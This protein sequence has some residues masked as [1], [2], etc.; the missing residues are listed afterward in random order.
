MLQTL[1]WQ[2]TVLAPSTLLFH[3]HAT[4]FEFQP[5]LWIFWIQFFMVF[6]S[7]STWIPDM[8]TDYI[9]HTSARLTCQSTIT[10]DATFSKYE[11]FLPSI[12]LPVLLENFHF[13]S[14][15][16]TCLGV[17]CGELSSLTSL[18]WLLSRREGHISAE[19]NYVE[20][21]WDEKFWCLHC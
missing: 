6:C 16:R 13:S 15:K 20:L 2:L 14:T 3:W 12:S 17:L 5:G 11:F 9:M 8:S 1:A 19:L 7:L 4:Q 18:L 21:M 10:F